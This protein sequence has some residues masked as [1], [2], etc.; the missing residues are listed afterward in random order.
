MKKNLI[1]LFI[2]VLL[3]GLTYYFVFKQDG[4]DFSIT[5]ANFTVKDTS[6]ITTI[7]LSSM[8]GESIKLNKTKT[9][10]S[11]NDSLVPREESVSLLLATLWE[12]KASQPVAL[13]IHDEAIKELST[14]STKVEIYEGEKLTRTFYVA[15][16]TAANN[17][18]YMLM[19]GAKRPYIVK[20]P[21]QNTFLGVRYMTQLSEWRTKQLLFAKSPIENIKIEF[22]DSVQHNFE[23]IVTDTIAINGNSTFTT[24]L[25]INRA[26]AYV[27]FYEGLFCYGY[28]YGYIYQD[29]IVKNG[30]QVGTVTLKRKNIP[31]EKLTIYF[32]P[33]VQDTKG[34]IKVG[35]NEYDMNVYFGLLNNKDFISIDNIAVE[36]MFRTY[37]EFYEADV[38]KDSL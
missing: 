23:V 12:Q 11:L 9:G 34:V 2:F 37:K 33:K 27:K 1:Y 32:K 19:E 16:N 35:G 26:K 13:N 31:T 10:W 5:E 36:K 7:F 21:F 6:A 8:K 14:N 22:K 28:E 38:K 3:A 29:T 4:S 30:L 15:K 25:N 24:P 20:F 17:L 18:T